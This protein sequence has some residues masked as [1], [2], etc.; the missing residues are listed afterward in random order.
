ME[1]HFKACRNQIKLGCTRKMIEP[2][3]ES[4]E[5]VCFNKCSTQEMV[6]LFRSVL[7]QVNCQVL[8]Q[9]RL[10]AAQRLR[11]HSLL[12]G[13]FQMRKKSFLI[14]HSPSD[15]LFLTLARASLDSSLAGP[16][17]SRTS[18]QH[19]TSDSDSGTHPF[20]CRSG[21]PALD[22]QVRRA[23]RGYAICLHL[24]GPTAR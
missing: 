24:E 4:P 7:E 15:T 16:Y 9:V 23:A 1:A 14:Y 19:P 13:G 6:W 17:D 18:E 21:V 20:D 22:S 11:G 10:K 2:A 12:V 5:P 3:A 8:M